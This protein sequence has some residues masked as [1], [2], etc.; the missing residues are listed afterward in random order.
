MSDREMMTLYFE[1]KEIH[2]R[3]EILKT[4]VFHLPQDGEAFF[5]KAFQKERYLDMKLCA[6]RG[7][8][9]YA[10]EEDVSKCMEKLLQLLRKR[11]QTT[12]Y[13][14]EEYEVMRSAYLMPYLL[15]T[16]GYACFSAFHEQLESQYENMPDVFKN[17]F[18]CDEF[19]N[20]YS[21][22]DPNEV[23]QSIAAFFRGN[24]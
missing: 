8:A 16:Y 14:Y 21:I 6:I 12:P 22:R 11:Q 17:I 4:L 13:N 23:K 24:G 9:A 5:L 1:T 19:G 20:S 3:A 10:A 18:S 15:A 2:K 7:Y